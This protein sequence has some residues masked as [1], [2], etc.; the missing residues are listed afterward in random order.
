[1]KTAPGM[2]P[3]TASAEE[4]STANAEAVEPSAAERLQMVREMLDPKVE[5][6]PAE[7]LPPG[8][9]HPAL[10][11][12]PAPK[13]SIFEE[14]DA[15]LAED[16]V[17]GLRLVPL[18]FP[19]L[20]AQGVPEVEFLEFPYVPREARIW[21]F[22]AAEASK[23][24]YFQWLAAKLT[25]TG[26]SVLFVSQENPLTTD[27]DRMVRLRPAFENL[28]YFHMPGLDLADLGHFSELV[29]ACAG[30]DL[31]VIDTLSACWSG[32]EGSN[33]DVVKLDRDVL[34]QLVRLTG[35]TVVIVHHTGHPQAFVSRG[36][37]GAGRGASAMGQKAD[38]VLV[39]Q[40]VGVHEFTLDHSK[41]RTPGGYKEPKARFRVL[42][43]DDGGL[44]VERVGKETDER[45]AEAMDAA[46]EVVAASD[47]TLSTNQLKAALNERGFGGSTVNPAL[48]ELKVEEPARVRPLD[49]DV[50][51]ADGKRR[52]GKPW[53][54]HGA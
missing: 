34:A 15:E 14:A 11:P 20:I 50:T 6:M 30:K 53:V 43:T 32:D 49:G 7:P 16:L 33:A 39:F 4:D 38:V 27:V 5:E 9:C 44:D 40:A 36:G 28:S 54:I 37:V 47:G 23:T 45:V 42:D 21:A 25:R 3:E 8:R 35:I 26:K 17:P 51:G 12:E 46:V 48:A 18:D 52:K 22:G 31:L 2:N 19:N 41:N 29:R 10:R 13:L 1:M 24:I